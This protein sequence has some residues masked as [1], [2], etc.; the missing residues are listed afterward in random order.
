MTLGRLNQ[1]A[2]PLAYLSR[3][4]RQGDE[5]T[6]QMIQD[7]DRVH[8]EYGR[9]FHPDNL[10]QMTAENFKGFLLYENNRHWW[11]IH[12]QQAMLVS[13]MPRLRKVLYELVDES[14]PLGERLD[15]VE[16]RGGVKPQPGLG[17]AVITPILHVVY[18]DR[19]GIWN[20]IAEGAMTRL[21]L[22]PAFPRGSA[23]GDQYLL[24][25]EVLKRWA[26][27]IGTDLWTLDALWW[28]VE[29]D[30]EPTRHQFEGSD[31]TAS[32]TRADRTSR[33]SPPRF[34]CRV[35][36]LSK[37]LNLASTTDHQACVDCLA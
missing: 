14:R 31:S 4:L 12:R 34:T 2:D 24:V 7:R 29:R 13:D 8:A 28:R 3:L 15:W 5:Q 18:P 33:K 26:D 35:C 37:P 27:R 17:R 22:W 11:G 23:F 30:H 19:Y 9:L 20:S 10:H 36:H 21:G 16:P 32:Y 1:A 25:N 6:R